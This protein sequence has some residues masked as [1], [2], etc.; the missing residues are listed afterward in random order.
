MQYTISDIEVGGKHFAAGASVE[1]TEN[2][3][4][5]VTQTW[6]AE[7]MGTLNIEAGTMFVFM[8]RRHNE[9]VVLASD[10]IAQVVASDRCVYAPDTRHNYTGID[11]RCMWCDRR[12]P[13]A[14]RALMALHEANRQMREQAR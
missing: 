14:L 1:V 2:V 13:G 3:A 4:D 5:G 8:D 6:P 11:Q 12:R 9:E 7:V 10:D